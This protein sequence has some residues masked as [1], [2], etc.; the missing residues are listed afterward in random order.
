MVRES[1]DEYLAKIKD[2]YRHANRKGKKRILDEFCEVCGHHRKHAIRLLNKD[3]RRKRKKP[4]R[5][6]QYGP[7]EIRVFESIWLSSNR[8]CASRLV[9]MVSLW[10][11]YYE[12]I[13]GDLDESCKEKLL[14]VKARTL[15]RLL[16]HVREKHGTRGLSGTKSGSYLKHSIPIKISHFDVKEPG[17]MQADTVAHC[18]ES[19]E[20]QFVWSL[21]FT[22]VFTGWTENGMFLLRLHGAAQGRVMTTRMLNKR[23]TLMSGSFLAMAE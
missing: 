1:K 8:P 19:L 14:A 16:H 9:G 3:G 18:G 22:D 6:S 7:E 10:L 2:R 5:P 13:H 15:D 20:G 21:T 23:T 11:P 12:I 4:G 17:F